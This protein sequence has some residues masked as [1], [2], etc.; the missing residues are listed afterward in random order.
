MSI[1]ST[2]LSY[3]TLYQSSMLSTDFMQKMVDNLRCNSGSSFLRFG[4]IVVMRHL[5]LAS[6]ELISKPESLVSMVRTENKE[7]QLSHD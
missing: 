6:A 5:T 3:S 7:A 1:F 4:G 2:D